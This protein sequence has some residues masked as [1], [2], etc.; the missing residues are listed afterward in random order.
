VTPD[1]ST[2]EARK[3]TRRVSA[4]G[5]TKETVQDFSYSFQAGRIYNILGPSGA[6]KSSLLRLLNRL[7]EPTSGEVFLDGADYR[8]LP[9]CTLRKRVGYLFQVPYLFPG[10]IADNVRYANPALTQ[11][12]VSDLLQVASFDSEKLDQPAETLSVGEK[13]RVALARLLA[14]DPKV[15]L[16]DEPTAALD[17]THTARIESSIRDIA[18]R[19]QLG[20]IIVSHNPE[21]AMRM[22]GEGLLLVSGR[23]EECGSVEQLITHP[24]SEAGRRYRDRELS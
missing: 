21:Q 2:L 3:L 9:P 11:D 5:A 22:G 7:D 15:V 23:L 6:G 8:T 19:K 12:Q 20:V 13:Q 16:L 1:V 18:V 4:N 10:S 24:Q 14:T 17:P